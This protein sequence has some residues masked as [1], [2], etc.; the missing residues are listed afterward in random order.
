M[1]TNSTQVNTDPAAARSNRATHMGSQLNVG[2]TSVSG[3]VNGSMGGSNLSINRR[4]NTELST[5]EKRKKRES[6]LEA[7]SM[8]SIDERT[9]GRSSVTSEP[10]DL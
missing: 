7:M 10:I 6:Y 9:S 8:G 1:V 3:S 2:S 4:D 5:S